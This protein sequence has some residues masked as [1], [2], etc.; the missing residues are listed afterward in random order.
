MA[1]V[2]DE[3]DVLDLNGL[4]VV[5]GTSSKWRRALF[6]SRF[7]DLSFSVEAA[8]IDE[9]AITADCDDRGSADPSRLTLA[10]AHAKARAILPRLSGDLLL[11]TS[12]QVLAFKGRI[13]EVSHL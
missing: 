9:S 5:L 12:D 4:S 3:A 8:D 11:I 6:A 7:P 10:L 13:R 1:A 2:T